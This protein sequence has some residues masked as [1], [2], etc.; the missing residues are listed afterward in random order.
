[1]KF[2]DVKDLI[3]E[4]FHGKYTLV[5]F[6]NSSSFSDIYLVR[7][8]FLNDLRVMKIIKKSLD[9]DS[10]L[11]LILYEARMA[12]QLKHENVVNIY[13]AGLIPANDKIDSDLVYFI[14][15]YVPGGDLSK[16]IISFR[17]SCMSIPILWTLSLIKQISF[18]L[19][20]LHS[21]DP[22]IVHGDIKPSNILLSFY[23]QNRVI[24]KLT[25]FGFSREINSNSFDS[26][27]VGTHQFMA[28]ECFN[29]EFYPSTDIYALGVIF[30]LLLTT[31]FPY[32]I[33]DFSMVEVIEGKPWR[34]PLVPPS[35]YNDKVSPDLDYIVMKCLDINHD[36]RFLDADELL[37]E[38][39]EY[40][41]NTSLFDKNT[42][43]EDYNVKK[44]FR[45]ALYENRLSDAIDILKDS[46]M[47]I[48][49]EEVVSFDKDKEL[50][51]TIKVE[52]ISKIF[53][54]N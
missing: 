11:N 9:V 44:A 25:D 13:D 34:I 47:G 38:V 29:K 7:H 39:D 28:P 23:S 31:R 3:E 16:Y 49:L 50:S 2:D 42:Y 10:N 27:I 41:D 36:E 18:G 14:M 54:G 4:L 1:M 19:T 46:G 43:L 33:D 15:E 40:L 37:K 48:I 21:S 24:V 20:S 30:Y 51:E 32:D 6:L 12:C 45:L 26:V 17:N 5:K 53:K 22:P 52:N 35:K 8:A